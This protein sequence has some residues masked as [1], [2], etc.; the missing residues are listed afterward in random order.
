MNV[1]KKQRS[2]S[3]NGIKLVYLNSKDKESGPERRSLKKRGCDSSKLSARR[4]RSRM[5]S[6]LL[7]K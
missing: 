7:R 3:L 1:R 4:R 5:S 2:C 6:F